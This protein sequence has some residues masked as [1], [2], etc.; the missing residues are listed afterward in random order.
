MEALSHYPRGTALR[1][2]RG[3]NGWVGFAALVAM[4]MLFGR[5]FDA[6]YDDSVAFVREVAHHHCG[7]LGI[8]LLAVLVVCGAGGWLGCR[9]RKPR[10]PSQSKAE[11]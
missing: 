8:P 11:L 7:A 6:N 10:N 5:Y 2:K 9:R 1:P 3:W 4:C